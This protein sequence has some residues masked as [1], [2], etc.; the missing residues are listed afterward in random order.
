M[1]DRLH[2]AAALCGSSRINI[3]HRQTQ[4][5]HIKARRERSIKCLDKEAKGKKSKKNMRS[6]MSKSRSKMSKSNIC[7]RSVILHI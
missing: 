6:K 7:T 1:Q 3:K 2:H 4:G 5:R